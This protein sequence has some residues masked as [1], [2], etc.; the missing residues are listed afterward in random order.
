MEMNTQREWR[1]RGDLAKDRAL[2]HTKV[3]GK[4]KGEMSAKE[5]DW[6]GVGEEE[7]GNLEENDG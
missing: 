3:P 5:T 7:R 6:Q 1:V 2:S 4:T